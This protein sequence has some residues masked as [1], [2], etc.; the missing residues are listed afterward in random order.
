M[1]F[2]MDHPNRTE[3]VSVE[4]WAE[5]HD[6]SAYRFLKHF[7]SI[8]EDLGEEKI[9]FYPRYHTWYCFSCK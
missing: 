6:P 4:L 8:F 7:K 5:P 2:K 9:K 3:V 1:T